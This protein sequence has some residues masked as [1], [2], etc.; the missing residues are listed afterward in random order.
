[1]LTRRGLP[2]VFAAV[3]VEMCASRR[4]QALP[5]RE[6]FTLARS[7]NANVVKYAVRT[8]RTGRL[9]LQ[10]PVEAYWLMLAEDGRR[11]ALTW[12]ERQLAYGFS[13][14]AMSSDG[15]VLHLAAC[16]QRA[17]R[18]RAVSGA[19]RAEL[20]IARQPAFLRRIFMQTDGGA[21]IPSLRYVEISGVDAGGRVVTE[22][23]VPR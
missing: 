7:K 4:L 15:F 19:Y 18:V 13:V 14:S 3:A 12:T 8:G 1:M 21:L 5:S 2:G 16:S 11:E 23:I 6:L 17:L 10:N 20:V 22:R 9:D